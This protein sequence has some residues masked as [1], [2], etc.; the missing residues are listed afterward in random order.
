MLGMMDIIFNLGFND[1]NVK[2]FVDKINDVWF[3]YDCYCCL[4]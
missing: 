2:K 1:D 4:L 3:V